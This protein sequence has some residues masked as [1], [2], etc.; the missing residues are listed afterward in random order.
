[1][2]KIEVL[3]VS[4]LETPIGYDL[5]IS[6]LAFDYLFPVLFGEAELVV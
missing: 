6:V 4:I 5:R 3:R 1:M 2:E